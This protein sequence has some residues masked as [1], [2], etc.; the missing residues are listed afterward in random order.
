M[1]WGIVLYVCVNKLRGL[2]FLRFTWFSFFFHLFFFFLLQI[3]NN[4]K[5][6][7]GTLYNLWEKMCSLVHKNTDTIVDNSNVQCN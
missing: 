4:I 2:K 6:N 5:Y 3:Y 7:A 1:K